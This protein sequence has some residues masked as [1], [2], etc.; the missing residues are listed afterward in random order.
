MANL[1]TVLI[2]LILTACGSK[3]DGF[4]PQE[5][6]WVLLETAA[7]NGCEIEMDSDTA[8]PA[9]LEMIDDGKGFTITPDNGDTG[10]T[11]PDFVCAL[12]GRDYTCD[13]FGDNADQVPA[14]FTGNNR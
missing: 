1:K 7:D 8:E 12:D 11:D 14:T 2:P 3:G 10:S 13:P 5:G 6:L 9:N 4:A